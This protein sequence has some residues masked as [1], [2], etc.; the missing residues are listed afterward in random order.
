[1]TENN[2]WLTAIN[3]NKD[4]L[5]PAIAVDVETGNVLTQA[6]MNEQALEQTVARGKATYWSRS[7]GKLWL[8]G[9]TSGNEQ[10]V[11][12][13]R[14]DC[15][16]DSILLMVKQSGNIACHTGRYSCFYFK[17]QDN[18]WEAVEPV[19]KSPDLIYKTET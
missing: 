7:R 3:W 14:T 6:W 8:K 11:K 13:I 12:E 10:L 1:M 18:S 16:K 15:D 4:G 17:L 5:V 9:E 19:I 2:E